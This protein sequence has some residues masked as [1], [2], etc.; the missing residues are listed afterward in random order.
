MDSR[1]RSREAGWTLIELVVTITVLTILTMGVVPLVKTSVTR[2]REQQLRESLRE[3][4][5]AIKAFHRDTVGMQCAA[6]G[7][8]GLGGGL[9][10]PGGGAPGGGV[11]GVGAPG[12]A[13]GGGGIPAVATQGAGVP[14]V[15]DP[16]SKVV[17]SDCT[18]FSLDNP[19]HYPP[20]LEAL[21][22]G[23]NVVPRATLGAAVPRIGEGQATDNRLVSTKKKQ[24]LRAIPVDP[25]TGKA[26]WALRSCYDASDSSEW[27]GENV[28]DVRSMST[29][30]ALDGSKYNEW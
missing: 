15:L 10:A 18:I 30:T 7:I 21:V 16:R 12:G 27:G 4:R 22:E 2:H 17:I 1:A 20:T 26:E 19:D 29:G 9:G 5:E 3:M 11:P 25:M 14:A 28:F 8:P 24:Y 6:G 23:V 13:T